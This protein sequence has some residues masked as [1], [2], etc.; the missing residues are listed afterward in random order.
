MHCSPVGRR[1]SR[2]VEGA[3]RLHVRGVPDERTRRLCDEPRQQPAPQRRYP[4][5]TRRLS[6]PR[7]RGSTRVAA[8]SRTTLS[9]ISAIDLGHISP[10]RARVRG[11][12]TQRRRRPSRPAA[13][14]EE[15][16]RYSRAMA[17]I[18][19]RYSWGMAEM[20]PRLASSAEVRTRCGQDSAE[21]WRR[22]GPASLAACGPHRSAP[23]RQR[24]TSRWRSRWRR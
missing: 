5:G 11:H 15:W 23:S 10:L 18:R 8:E 21:A 4:L 13:P 1:S 6:E 7:S 20:R 12:H 14:A 16:L 22:G 2:R 9:R 3:P 17:E 19:P 24:R